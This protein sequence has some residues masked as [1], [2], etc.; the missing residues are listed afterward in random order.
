MKRWFGL[1]A[2]LLLSGQSLAIL[3]EGE[4]KTIVHPRPLVTVEVAV[5]LKSL[6]QFKQQNQVFRQ[7]RVLYNYHYDSSFTVEFG[8]IA[9]ETEILNLDCA[10]QKGEV[11]TQTLFRRISIIGHDD[12]I[13]SELSE[14][15]LGPF[16]FDQQVFEKRQDQ[17][18]T[19]Q[20][21][22]SDRS[23]AASAICSA[24][25]SSYL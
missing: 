16:V 24:S 22:F 5:D 20:N 12:Q 11:L 14:E 17:P 10:N 23:A 8:K 15:E 4:W 21:R 2:G 9:S 7:G 25:L 3:P 6:T 18:M 19:W 13:T 1:F